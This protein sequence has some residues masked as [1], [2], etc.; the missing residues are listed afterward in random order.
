MAIEDSTRIREVRNTEKVLEILGV[1]VD[2][3]K[4]GR[5]GKEFGKDARR[6]DGT[7]RKNWEKISKKGE[8]TPDRSYS[9][10]IPIPFPFPVS[11]SPHSLPFTRFC[12]PPQPEL[13]SFSYPCLF[14]PPLFLALCHFPLI[15]TL[16]PLPLPDFFATF[17]FLSTLIPQNRWV[18]AALT[19]ASGTETKT[20]EAEKRGQIWEVEERK[21]RDFWKRERE[22]ERHN[23][24]K[25]IKATHR[26]KWIIG[27]DIRDPRKYQLIKAHLRF[28]RFYRF[29]KFTGLWL[30]VLCTSNARINYP[31][32]AAMN[33]E[34]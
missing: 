11:E 25:R 9:L 17:L 32:M 18:P 34:T 2:K 14:P 7:G 21:G 24:L 3:K 30:C 19:Q 1:F 6:R 8:R 31:S 26:G 28:T 20:K 13:F 33:Q 4:S 22:R 5:G 23:E 10:P 12:A 16:F 29:Q 27:R 15:S